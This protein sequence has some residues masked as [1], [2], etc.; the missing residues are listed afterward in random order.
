MQRV[1][2][3]LEHEGLSVWIDTERIPSDSP[4][5]QK[6]IE[7]AIE[8]VDCL[9]VIFSPDAKKS[10][11]VRAELDYAE[12]QH[13]PIF[14]LLARGTSQNAIPL[15]HTGAHRFD[16]RDG[17][18]SELVIH[19]LINKICARFGKES[20]SEQTRIDMEEAGRQ[21]ELW[22]KLQGD[23]QE[24][25][26]G[27][28]TLEDEFNPIAAELDP[29]DGNPIHSDLLYGHRY[30]EQSITN[31]N[32]EE[33]HRLFGMA[34]A[35][36]NH[37]PGQ[38]EKAKKNLE[39][40][41]E[42][43]RQ[44][45]LRAEQERRLWQALH[46]DRQELQDRLDRFVESLTSDEY[47]QFLGQIEPIRERLVQVNAPGTRYENARQSCDDAQNQIEHL[48]EVLQDIRIRRQSETQQP[49]PADSPKPTVRRL[50]AANPLNWLRVIWW[51]FFVP[52]KI[53]DYKKRFGE[54]ALHRLGMWP[55][56]T[57]TW[58]PLF[59]LVLGLT[60]GSF[61]VP[62][63]VSTKL[64]WISEILI[65]F[66]WGLTGILGHRDEDRT[67]SVLGGIAIFAVFVIVGELTGVSAG[68]IMGGI[69][70]SIAC[71]IVGGISFGMA[72]GVMS[73]DMVK[74]FMVKLLAL[75]LITAIV[76][77]AILGD[78]QH[79]IS[80]SVSGGIIGSFAYFPVIFIVA[81]VAA[82]IKN[83]HSNNL[84]FVIFIFSYTTLIWICFFGGDKRF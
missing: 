24:L 23:Q 78:I 57:L 83:Q 32:Y 47:G 42:A 29:E 55:I 17:A 48:E 18:N 43:R 69:A 21:R 1:K 25:Q 75:L 71:S 5:W 46:E 13:K 56:S 67:I 9:L 19:E 37:I 28:Q 33:A 38:L 73:D 35:L 45:E 79:G 64:L 4:D 62:E 3:N 14:R 84:S 27:L 54:K 81:R 60:I 61:P 10:K 36:A 51:V 44:R 76:I 11:W 20:A 26:R 63:N 52:E 12:A 34:N 59:L 53:T 40:A 6:N 41:K 49:K 77:G 15:G 68:G 2:N 30:L 72:G 65:L 70:G 22:H 50:S 31:E 74:R 8:N 80:I 82:N 39:D 16:I 58:L 66:A 7:I